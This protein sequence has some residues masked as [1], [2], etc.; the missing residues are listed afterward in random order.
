MEHLWS[1][2]NMTRVH[3][4]SVLPY[5]TS[6]LLSLYWRTIGTIFRYDK[7]NND[8]KTMFFF[9]V[10]FMQKPNAN[11]TIAKQYRNYIVTLYSAVWVISPVIL[12]YFSKLYLNKIVLIIKFK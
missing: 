8:K 11:F 2:S 3:V 1:L 4:D 7:P 9:D 6:H 12:F 5:F 10:S